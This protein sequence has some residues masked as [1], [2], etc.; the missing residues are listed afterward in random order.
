MKTISAN[1]GRKLLWACGVLSACAMMVPFSSA[2]Q[3]ASRIPA[4]INNAERA[5]IPNSQHPLAQPQYDAGRMAADTRLDGITLNFS[6]SPQQ[7]A[8][9]K[10]LIAAQQ[11]PASPLYH[12]WLNP[13]QFAARYGMSDS[14]ISKVENW[15]QEQGFTIE[16]VA[17]SKNAIHF[18]GTVRQVE[19]AFST[20]MHSYKINGT[21]HFAP[22]TALSVP[23]AFAGTV[24]S[25][26]NLDDFRPRAQVILRRNMRSRANFT[27]AG[28]TNSSNEIILFAPG[29]I[30]TA[31]DI[32]PL[33]NGS[34]TGAGQSI[35]I[36]GQ[37]AVETSDLEAF[38][39]AAGLTVKDPT[40]YLV[41]NTGD[42]TVQA[43]GDEAE[44]DLDLEWSN[45]IA[46]GAT[47]NFVYTGSNTNYGAF[48]SIVY[49]IDNK[50]GTIVSSSYGTCET[51]L[52]GQTLESNF[53]QGTA[54]GQSFLAA[55]GDDGST[56]C[57]GISSLSTTQQE[58][59]AVD[60]PASSVYVTGMGGT[61]IDQSNSNYSTVGDGYW[62][63]DSGTSDIVNSVL[64][65]IPE[66]VWNDDEANCGYSNCLSATGGGAS[67]LFAKPSWQTGVTGIP[68]GT[69][70]FV[71]DLAL[72]ASPNY[73]G[74]LYCSS[75]SS[76]WTSGQTSSCTS[77]FEDA[78][79]GYLTAAGG[80][81]FDGPIFSG[82][83]ALI[84]QK[85]GYTT[86][87]GLI[88]PTL[89]QLASNSATY[90]LAFHDITS[91]NNDCNA[92]STNCSSSAGFSANVGYDE[93]TGLGSVDAFNLAT[94]WPASSGGGSLI[95]T[96]TTISAANSSPNVNTSDTFTVT[97]TGASGTPTGTVNLT[98]DGGTPISEALSSNGTYVYTTSFATAGDHTILAAYVA[99]STYA[100]STG[101]V[102][103]NVA[104]VSSGSG[105]F[106]LGATPSTLS[107][108]DGSSGSE[109]ITVTPKSGYT[110]TVDLTFDTS[111][112]SAL[113]NLCY[114]FTDTNSA[115][116]GLVPI[117]GTAAVTT[118]LTLDTNAAD[119]ASTAALRPSGKRAF[120][121]IHRATT[122]KNDSKGPLPFTVAFAGLLLVGFLGRSS[123]KF[124][125]LVAVLALAVVGLAVT[126]CGSS[127]NTQFNNPPAGTYTIT[128]TGQDSVTS[129]IS[130]T[131]TFTFVI[132]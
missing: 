118:Q 83:L 112:D 115:G 18:A 104:T 55:A 54:Q 102:T 27:G 80:T 51:A 107:V 72:Y 8:D 94:A 33:Y 106:T 114:E 6:R 20:E 91:G 36:V 125:G 120:R 86:G 53:E 97:V 9:L 84:N 61:E 101:S 78:Q 75:D 28:S 46:P 123:R 81:S 5:T 47:I 65:Y 52:G 70:R 105:T 21:R 30:K 76:A 50:I 99:N 122:A 111:N 31:Y 131:T 19:Q 48:D 113:Q 2:E 89:Y 103:V 49:A 62:E 129:T 58:A 95:A 1:S 74:Y 87:Q 71:P 98:I 60:Y 77:G 110:G 4:E 23:A 26:K 29:D 35:T 12:Q 116:Y 57:Y 100:A 32:N 24:L 119:C 128:V 37:S 88:N 43:D 73:P 93:V 66:V 39:S 17:R 68:S 96:T 15:L 85:Q 64:Q 117:T 3:V 82:I 56:D 45:A 126:A 7:E 108:S 132:N 16:S 90:A 10:A 40:L 25:I 14:D 22:S 67:I 34:V 59:L 130:G 69:N 127:V 41:P 63:A 13:D 11:N 79:T 44:S 124:R 121:A 92:G 38:Q 109:T 42:S